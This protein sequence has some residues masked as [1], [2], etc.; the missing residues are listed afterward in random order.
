MLLRKEKGVYIACEHVFT[1]VCVNMYVHVFNFAS[2]EK[3]W[4]KGYLEWKE[5]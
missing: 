5:D 2:E 4:R 1:H 3:Q